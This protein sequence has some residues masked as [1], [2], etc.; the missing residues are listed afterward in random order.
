MNDFDA[1]RKWAS[2]AAD[3]PGE[4]SVGSLHSVGLLA[5][6]YVHGKAGTTDRRYGVRLAGL[7]RTMCARYARGGP[8]HEFALELDPADIAMGNAY[9]V[10]WFRMLDMQ[11][12]RPLAEPWR[13]PDE[14]PADRS[15]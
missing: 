13:E 3:N 8:A 14:Q 6:I 4:F 11:I 5:W 10:A 9:A 7:Y 15:D 2:Q 12:R 1:A